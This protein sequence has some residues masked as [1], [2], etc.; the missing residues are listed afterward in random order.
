M[1]GADIETQ[2]PLQARLQEPLPMIPA[3]LRKEN[4]PPALA[5]STEKFNDK[6]YIDNEPQR[7]LVQ[8]I[9]NEESPEFGMKKDG[10]GDNPFMHEF[11]GAR[12]DAY[13]ADLEMVKKHAD[14][15]LERL[16]EKGLAKEIGRRVDYADK[17]DLLY[18]RQMPGTIDKT[19]LQA[20]A[21]YN[22][23]SDIGSESSSLASLRRGRKIKNSLLNLYFGMSDSAL[24]KLGSDALLFTTSSRASATDQDPLNDYRDASNNILPSPW[25]RRTTTDEDGKKKWYYLNK[26][27]YCTQ[28]ANPVDNKFDKLTQQNSTLNCKQDEDAN[29][30]FLPDGWSKDVYQEYKTDEV[31]GEKIPIASKIRY[32]YK[33]NG[34]TQLE[35]PDSKDP[36]SMTVTA[37]TMTKAAS[38]E[39]CRIPK[40]ED[41]PDRL[42]VYI[43]D[44]LDTVGNKFA[45][46]KMAVPYTMAHHTVR[47]LRSMGAAVK[48]RL[49]YGKKGGVLRKRN[50]TRH[51]KPKR[52][53]RSGQR[54]QISSRRHR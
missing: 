24:A 27:T 14:L 52:T 29:G 22:K 12:Y 34:C 4:D 38:D 47:G 23:T 18:A 41:L 42:P 50:R 32:E 49:T 8:A 48:S 54:P 7:N 5:T 36:H 13:K 11:E 6:V 51:G 19:L 39:T 45:Y 53:R 35:D 31:T 2:V 44:V 46:R 16:R 28:W 26:K 15:L 33:P 10:T 30:W 25:F 9:Y 3:G 17:V 37:D 21:R 40:D 20:I 43:P 1:Q